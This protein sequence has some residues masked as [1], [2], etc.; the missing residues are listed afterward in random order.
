MEEARAVEAASPAPNLY[1]AGPLIDG[2]P[3][4]YDGANRFRPAIGIET[5]GV[6]E[7][8]AMVNRVANAGAD[9]IKAYEM[10]TPEQFMAI[11]EAAHARGLPVTAHPP[12][13]LTMEEVIAAGV[14]EFQHL[15]NLEL[16]CSREHDALYEARVRSFRERDPE[17]DGGTLRSTIHTAPRLRADTRTSAFMLTLVW[18][19]G[20]ASSTSSSSTS[21]SSTLCPTPTNAM[22]SRGTASTARKVPSS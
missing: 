15:R 2:T 10:L 16:A 22:I 11:I 5:D 6:D 14:D 9:L 18:N 20:S 12:L 1:L 7:A 8:V 21:P 19:G 3:R 4:V 17:T 13:Q